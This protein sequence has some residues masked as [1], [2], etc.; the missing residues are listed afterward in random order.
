MRVFIDT[1]IL[2]DLICK[3]EKFIENAKKIFLYA[4]DQKITL[5]ISA[6]SYINTLYIAKRYDFK[7]EEIIKA[8]QIISQFSIITGFDEDTI[9]LALASDWK[10]MEDAVQYY[11]ALTTGI[12]YIVTRNQKDFQKSNIPIVSPDEIIKLIEAK[13]N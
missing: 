11:S 3:R 7:Q 6:L 10:D 5:A 1:N 12:D 4:Y 9:K 2:V 13:T 8:L